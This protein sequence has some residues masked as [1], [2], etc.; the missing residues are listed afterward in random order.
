MLRRRMRRYFYKHKSACQLMVLV[1]ERFPELERSKQ[2]ANINYGCYLKC[3][4]SR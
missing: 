4:E 1:K 2:L 3:A